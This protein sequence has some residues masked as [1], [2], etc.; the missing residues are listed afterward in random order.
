MIQVT[1]ILFAACHSPGRVPAASWMLRMEVLDLCTG[2][3]KSSSFTR[4]K[5]STSNNPVLVLRIPSKY[6]W[7]SCSLNESNLNQLRH[8]LQPCTRSILVS[9]NIL[10]LDWARDM[11]WVPNC[12]SCQSALNAYAAWPISVKLWPWPCVTWGH[13]YQ[14]IFQGLKVYE[15]ISLDE[16]NMMAAKHCSIPNSVEVIN[17]KYCPWKLC[18]LVW[19][20]MEGQQLSVDLKKLTPLDSKRPKLFCWSLLRSCALKPQYHHHHHHISIRAR[21]RGVYPPPSPQVCSVTSFQPVSIMIL[22]SVYDCR[23]RWTAFVPLCRTQRQQT[24]YRSHQVQDVHGHWHSLDSRTT[25]Q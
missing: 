11:G 16:R 15:S 5:S 20:D 25:M 8:K 14:V 21:W 13:I 22:N 10:W 12:S 18:S 3:H 23:L 17:K 7:M 9:F 24:G 6:G 4:R 2:S 1:S 19:P